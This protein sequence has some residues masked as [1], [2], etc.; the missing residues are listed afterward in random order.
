[1]RDAAPSPGADALRAALARAEEHAELLEEVFEAS[2]AGL[3]L[4]DESLR[5]LKVNSAYRALTARPDL[6]PV[7]RHFAE[8]WPEDSARPLEPMLRRLLDSGDPVHVESWESRAGPRPRTFALD[9]M[10]VRY[11]GRPAI[12]GVMW[13]TT[14]LVAA[15]RAAEAAA[16]AAGHTAAELDATLASIPHG[17]IVYGAD[18][19]IVR[20]NVAADALLGLTPAQRALP[21][22][23]RFPLLRLRTADGQPVTTERS[24]I[25][26]ALRGERV[27]T[28]TYQRAAAVPGAAPTWLAFTAAPIVSGA[29]GAVLAVVDVTRDRQLVALR[30]ELLGMI[31][32]DLRT[33]LQAVYAQAHLLRRTAGLPPR[34]LERARA[35]LR[36]CDRMTGMLNDL[37]DMAL[38]EAGHLKL[39]RAPLDLGAFVSELLERLR[40]PLAAERVRLDVRGELPRVAADPLRLERVVMNL[41]SNALKYSPAQ[42]PVDVLL[43]R[44]DGG[45][46]LSVTDRGVGISVEDQA[47]I[48]GRFFRVAGGRSPEGL[49]LGLYI[50]RL[51]VEAHGGNIDVRSAP[52]LGSTFTVHLPATDAAPP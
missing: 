11:G 13:E 7:G 24:P 35:I 33:P 37:L 14:D 44:D 28:E 47:L 50:A 51:L 21:F 26:R 42:S 32:H 29:G 34:V 27:D 52:G 41:V 48:F 4:G 22:A 39:A 25:A 16:A 2:T 17:V 6:D 46:R 10:R 15:R 43:E 19:D 9:V 30:E 36:S 1:M 38:V 45:V 20:T 23:E 12:L 3:A 31:S 18:G 8:V 40:A 5:Y 49:G